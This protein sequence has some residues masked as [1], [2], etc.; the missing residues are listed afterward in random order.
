MN[1]YLGFN[2]RVFKNIINSTD[3]WSRYKALGKVQK[4]V[5]DSLNKRLGIYRDRNETDDLII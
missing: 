5:A 1:K 3:R 4:G 2:K